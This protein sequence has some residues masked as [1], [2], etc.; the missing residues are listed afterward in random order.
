MPDVHS[1][2]SQIGLPILVLDTNAVLD[3]LVFRDAAME[4]LARAI[5]ESKVHW[6]TTERMRRE[7]AHV[8]A[9]QW[10]SRWTFVADACLAQ[11]DRWAKRVA[12]PIAAEVAKSLPG[13]LCTD[14]DDQVFIDLALLAK[15]KWLV[16]RDLAVLR[17]SRRLSSFGVLVR[18]PV[19]WLS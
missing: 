17:L 16:S 4:P 12:E 15:A 11:Y 6:L 9:R 10:P 2:S 8:L 14:P 19:D 13:C 18:R 7:L 3:W 1:S 5:T